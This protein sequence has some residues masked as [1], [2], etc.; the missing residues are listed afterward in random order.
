M[1]ITRNTNDTTRGPADWF[2]GEVY[3][4]AVA[5]P[6][7]DSR[8]QAS[9]VHFLPGARTAWHRH[10]NGQTIWVTEGTGLCQSR[11][12]AV[13]VIRPG[14]RVRFEPG[15]EHWHG[16]TATR[17]MVHI[18]IQEVGDDGTPAAWGEHVTDE[19][20]AAAPS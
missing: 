3:I 7:G 2:T 5:A 20:Y 16:A 19:E 17:L 15:E 4:D 6:G 9:N 13:E 14:D 10:P 12:G 18:A 8:V 1:E 11:G